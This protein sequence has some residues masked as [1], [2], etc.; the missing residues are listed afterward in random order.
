MRRGRRASE[1]LAAAAGYLRDLGVPDPRVDAE[2]LLA[3]V[4]KETRERIL[5]IGDDALP[6]PRIRAFNRAVARRGAR[7][8]VAYITGVKEFYG[9]SLKVTPS[10]LIPR[11]ETEILVERAI[12]LHP[13]RVLDLGTGSGAIAAALAAALPDAEIVATDVSAA[14]LG[15]AKKNLPAR[16]VLKEGPEFEPVRGESF[17][18]VVSNPPYIPTADIDGL[19]P[20]VR[21]EPRIAL[22]GGPDGLAFVRRI[23]K[24][25]KRALV[26]IGA[27][28]SDVLR[29]EFRGVRFHKD[30]TG[31]ERVV[32]Q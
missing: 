26:E 22:D 7:E 28:Q 9:L 27:G 30:L 1:L 19:D 6:L 17:D 29:S 4:L 31:I 2:I 11:P 10:V 15:I 18:L 20:E 3:H 14:A 16:V 8:P 5:L 32:E 24:G 25:A 12:A 13:R 21:K 23:L